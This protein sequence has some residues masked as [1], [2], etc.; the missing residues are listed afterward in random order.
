[1]AVECAPCPIGLSIRVNVQ[2]DT[3]DLTP[4]SAFLI[5]IK[6]A[7]IGDEGP[8]AEVPT[9]AKYVAKALRLLAS[10]FLDNHDERAMWQPLGSV[11]RWQLIRQ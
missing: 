1:V 11:A 8:Q 10:V 3:P 9:Y 7:E 6:E 2:N 4:V 5:G